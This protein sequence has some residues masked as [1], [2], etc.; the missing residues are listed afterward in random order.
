VH[1][2][3]QNGRIVRKERSEVRTMRVDCQALWLAIKRPQKI[4]DEKRP[5]GTMKE[6]VAPFLRLCG[7]FLAKIS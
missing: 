5:I 3:P 7:V 6:V 2:S 1:S 4:R